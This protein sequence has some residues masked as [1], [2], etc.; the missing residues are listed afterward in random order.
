MVELRKITKD[1]YEECLK[2]SVSDNQKILFHQP[3]T[4]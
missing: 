3:F 4:I 1:N 2:L